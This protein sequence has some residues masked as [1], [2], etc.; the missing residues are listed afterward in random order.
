MKL[1][2]QVQSSSPCL[3]SGVDERMAGVELKIQILRKLMSTFSNWLD[4]CDQLLT[5]IPTE[6]EQCS[7]LELRDLALKYK[8]C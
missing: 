6:L 7:A 3:D 8:V 2:Q 1:S 4:D 5:S